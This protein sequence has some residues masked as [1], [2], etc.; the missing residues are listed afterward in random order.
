MTSAPPID[1]GKLGLLPKRPVSLITDDADPGP[2][3]NA[4]AES[5]GLTAAPVQGY[6]IDDDDDD[7]LEYAENPFEEPA[8][9]K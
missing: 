5:S 2:E 9:K 6:S 1:G 8:H 7:G 3:K 4:P